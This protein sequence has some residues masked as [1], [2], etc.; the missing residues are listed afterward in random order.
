MDTAQ[1]KKFKVLLIGD[2]CQDVYQYGNADRISPEAPVPV[3]TP[4]YKETKPG[5]AA[6]VLE[7][8]KALDINSTFLTSMKSIKTRLIDIKSKQHLVR[9]DE[10]HIA[11]KP[12]KFSAIDKDTLK[13]DAIV[14]S[15]YDK[16]F[17]S[18]E[19]IEKLRMTFDGSIFIDTKK[20]DLKR[21]DNC[22]VKIN[23]SEYGQATSLNNEL[24][25]TLGGNGARYNKTAF[26]TPKVD[27]VDVCGAGDTFL[28]ALVYRY[29]HTKSIPDSI[30][31]A[32]RAAAVTVNHVGVYAPTIKEISNG[33]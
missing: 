32:N 12:L 19:L 30:N 15:D 23:E 9:I 1:P 16:G 5:M 18:Y 13:V 25:V 31:F 6:N 26:P 29:L 17:V 7:N 28:A 10:D 33:N 3:F 11:E 8:L 27:V 24:I 14:I 2:N 22:F 20:R 4:K 21:F